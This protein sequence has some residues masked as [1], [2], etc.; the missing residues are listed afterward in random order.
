M[1][2]SGGKTNMKRPMFQR[3]NSVPVE[4]QSKSEIPRSSSDP[5]ALNDPAKLDKL[6]ETLTFK[7]GFKTPHANKHT[8][9]GYSKFLFKVIV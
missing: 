5:G 3:F 1:H 7:S 6:K 9:K 2:I 4:T 8:K